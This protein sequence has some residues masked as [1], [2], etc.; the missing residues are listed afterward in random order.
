[1]S[2]TQRSESMNALLKLWVD[3]HKSIYQ[4]VMQIEKMIESIWQKE[5]DEDLR[6]MNETP[7][8]Y[9]YY[10]LENE[11]CQVYTRNVF[12][13]FKEIIKES[14]LGFAT[15]ITRDA[16][17]Q[18]KITYHPFFHNFKPESYMI[19]VDIEN[20]KVTCS[21]KGFE[22]EGLL[23]SHSIKVMHHIGMAHLPIYYILKRWTKG[24]NA[25]SKRPISER[26][27]DSGESSELRCLRFVS[28]LV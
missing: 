6:C 27:M 24:A 16:L 11:A 26:S 22:M 21:C 1:M 23:C 4:F 8:T 14:S 12:S 25:N 19:D 15:E 3:N 7:H 9:S 28:M 18:V 17:Y 20:N 2:T 13:V 5:S 10:Q